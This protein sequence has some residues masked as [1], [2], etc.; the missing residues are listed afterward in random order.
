MHSDVVV[1]ASSPY[2]GVKIYELV[3][4][5]PLAAGGETLNLTGVACSFPCASLAP[6]SKNIRLWGEIATWVDSQQRSPGGK[7][8]ALELA[9]VAVFRRGQT[10]A[11]TAVNLHV[12]VGV[13]VTARR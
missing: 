2:P 7:C 5:Y 13:M 11:C 10:P 6:W 9:S 12:G 4:S 3:M 8:L 1:A